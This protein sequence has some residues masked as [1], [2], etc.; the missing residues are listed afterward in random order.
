MWTSVLAELSFSCWFLV[1]N[2]E[3]AKEGMAKTRNTDDSG[4]S[5]VIPFARL[6]KI[7][8]FAETSRLVCKVT[9]NL[10]WIIYPTPLGH[11]WGL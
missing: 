11:F 6:A 7:D 8:F 10:R 5:C 3:T 9:E 2:Q 4:V 1:L